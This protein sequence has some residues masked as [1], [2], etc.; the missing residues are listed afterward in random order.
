VLAHFDHLGF[1]TPNRLGHLNA[2]AADGSPGSVGAVEE[3][4]DCGAN[5]LGSDVK[6]PRRDDCLAG[7]PPAVGGCARRAAGPFGERARKR[8]GTARTAQ[9]LSVAKCCDRALVVLL[10]NYRP[11]VSADF[12]WLPPMST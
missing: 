10:E 11:R 3:L 5:D 9:G 4:L 7:N 6:R 8:G 2:P 1:E 12:G